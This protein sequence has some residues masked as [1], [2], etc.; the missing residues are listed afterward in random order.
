[1]IIIIKHTYRINLWGFNLVIQLHFIELFLLD[2]LE[3]V[4]R[5]KI[6]KIKSHETFICLILLQNIVI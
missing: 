3:I 2:S 5:I 6:V 1:M 4:L